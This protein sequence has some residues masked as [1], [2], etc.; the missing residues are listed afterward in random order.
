MEALRAGPG[1]AVRPAGNV[2][3]AFCDV[4]ADQWFTVSVRSGNG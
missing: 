4:S 2:K 3:R 1:S